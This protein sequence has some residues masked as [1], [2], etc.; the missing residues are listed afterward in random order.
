MRIV[1]SEVLGTVPGTV[2]PIVRLEAAGDSSETPPSEAEVGAKI[3][4]GSLTFFSDNWTVS[5]FSEKEA[6]WGEPK[7]MFG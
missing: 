5:A 1:F 2:T 6:D 4:D 3:A 7:E